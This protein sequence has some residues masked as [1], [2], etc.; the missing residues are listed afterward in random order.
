MRISWAFKTFTIIVCRVPASKQGASILMYVL[1]T[2]WYR[3]YFYSGRIRGV[4]F[5]DKDRYLMQNVTEL[6]DVNVVSYVCVIIFIPFSVA[7]FRV[8]LLFVQQ[9]ELAEEQQHLLNNYEFL[10]EMSLGCFYVGFL[11]K[12]SCDCD[13]TTKARD[14]YM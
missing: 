14:P 12:K 3:T 4:G 11:L 5:H 7:S 9:A 10:L 2:M 8:K 13:P 6:N 1:V